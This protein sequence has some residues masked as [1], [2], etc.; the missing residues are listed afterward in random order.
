MVFLLCLP[1]EYLLHC[2]SIFMGIDLEI[3]IVYRV[4]IFLLS[5]T[6]K[7]FIFK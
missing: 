1:Y 3:T 7:P 2:V 5:I 4:S 6:G